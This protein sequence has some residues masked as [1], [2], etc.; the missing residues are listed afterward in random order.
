[1]SL[2]SHHVYLIS[3]ADTQD[4]PIKFGY[5]HNPPNRLKQLQ[6]G[7]PRQLF[8]YGNLGFKDERA[9]RVV[10]KI[11]L[12][13]LKE[14]KVNVNG[15]WHNININMGLQILEFFPDNAEKL[16][17][18]TE[19]KDGKIINFIDLIADSL[20]KKI[21]NEDEYDLLREIFWNDDEYQFTNFVEELK[22]IT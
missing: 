6:T 2:F 11:I 17:E 16:F 10:E 21:I 18:P 13:Y 5:S 22:K 9:A 15:E 8:I 12:S 14:N 19:I 7:N 1:M 4:G 20:E 3:Y